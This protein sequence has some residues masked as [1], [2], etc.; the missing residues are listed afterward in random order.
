MMKKNQG[1]TLVELMIVV[2]IIGILAA[3]GYPSYQSSVMKS[4]RADAID[5]LLV[6]TGRIEEYYLI[7]DTYNNTA[8][9]FAVANGGVSQEGFYTITVS[10]VTNFAYLLTAT[11]TP[12]TDPDC[13][14]LTL[15]QLGVKAATG[16]S[17][18]SCW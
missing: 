6:E 1:F 9:P 4:Q 3:V 15:D 7:N 8:T 12:A 11:R 2:A 14:T 18:A 5:A 17:P 13:L 16:A 10:G